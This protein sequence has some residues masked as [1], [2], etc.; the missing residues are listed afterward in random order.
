MT[1][2]GRSFSVYLADTYRIKMYICTALG[3]AGPTWSLFTE[4]CSSSARTRKVSTTAIAS[5]TEQ[6]KNACARCMH[7]PIR[8]LHIPFRTA[9]ACQ[10][11]LNEVS[12]CTEGLFDCMT[13]VVRFFVPLLQLPGLSR[14]LRWSTPGHPSHPHPYKPPAVTT[15]I[16]T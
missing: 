7:Y 13:F 12:R 10:L 9:S 1:N 3:P 6:E 11:K 15:Q 5:K 2:G 14:S 16:P 4:F 8:V